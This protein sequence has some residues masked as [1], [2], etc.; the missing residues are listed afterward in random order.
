MVGMDVEYEL[1]TAYQSLLTCLSV[2][3]WG[4]RERAPLTDFVRRSSM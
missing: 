2:L 4:C 1:T 3:R